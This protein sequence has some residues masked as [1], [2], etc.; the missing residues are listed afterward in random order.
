MALTG[1]QPNATASL[2]TLLALRDEAVGYKVWGMVSHVSFLVLIGVA[3]FYRQALTVVIAIFALLLSL[4]YHACLSFDVCMGLTLEQER[5]ND[6]FSAQ[7]CLILVFYFLA[8]MHD[9][10]IKPRDGAENVLETEERARL[11]EGDSDHVALADRDD[12]DIG[13]EFNPPLYHLHWNQVRFFLHHEWGCMCVHTRTPHGER[14]SSYCQVWLFTAVL[15]AGLINYNWPLDDFFPFY[16][17]AVLGILGWFLYVIFRLERPLQSTDRMFMLQ[18]T[19]PHW[20]WFVVF[21][22]LAGAA[23]LFFI[24]PETSNSLFHSFWHFFSAL[25]LTALLLA[26]ILLPIGPVYVVYTSREGEEDREDR[27][28]SEDTD[29]D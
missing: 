13:D 16:V 26:V 10:D 18:P 28:D 21:L 25:A 5:R 6:H 14:N 24:L 19:R 1:Y 22:I 4:S 11:A 8:L 2:E 3:A 23:V 9:L 12:G 29:S 15:C 17:V 20:G 27:E 7:L